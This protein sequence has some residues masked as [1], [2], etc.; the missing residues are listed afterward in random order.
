MCSPDR[1]KQTAQN[2]CVPNQV[3]NCLVLGK[4]HCN[5][6]CSTGLHQKLVTTQLGELTI[7]ASHNSLGLNPLT[8][9]MCHLVF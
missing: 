8:D 5:K 7:A 4:T 3:L 6:H 1:L 2:S 9:S